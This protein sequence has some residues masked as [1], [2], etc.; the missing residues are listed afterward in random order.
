M[1]KRSLGKSGIEVSRLCFGTLALSYTQADLPPEEGGELIVYAAEKGVSFVDTAQLYETY[2]HIKY[3]LRHTSQKI[4]IS[5]KSYA[6]D[7]KTAQE[8]VEQARRGTDADVIDIFMLH[9]QESV[10]TMTGHKEALDYYLKMKDKGII[11]AV[12]ISTHAI[13]PVRAVAQAKGFNPPGFCPPGFNPPGFHPPKTYQTGSNFCELSKKIDENTNVDAW[14]GFDPGRY[15]EIDVIH[16]ILN[17]TGIGLIDGTAA[18][19]RQA[20]EDAHSVGAG[21]LGMKMLG[22]GN[23]FNDFDEAVKY[24]LSIE[25]ADAYAVGM[26]NRYE[27][28]MNVALFENRKVPEELLAKTKARKR[29]LKIEDWCVGCGLCVKQCKTDALRIENGK[30]CVDPEKCV[31]CSYCARVCREFAIK[32]I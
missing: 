26:Q 28:D 17:M 9:E 21:I 14:T 16:P 3:A 2:A 13:E 25:A 12:G 32:V 15:R 19:M 4:V 27:I 24:A 7:A 1:E 23:L 5:T 6:F 29:V 18:Q 20:V 22:G 31:L 11:R 8:S 10:L 30:G